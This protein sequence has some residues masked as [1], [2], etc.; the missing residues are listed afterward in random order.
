[1]AQRYHFEMF[2]EVVG[3]VFVVVTA[4]RVDLGMSMHL[5]VQYNYFYTKCCLSVGQMHFS[6]GLRWVACNDVNCYLPSLG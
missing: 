2:V 5:G 4:L 1:M 6:L 3:D